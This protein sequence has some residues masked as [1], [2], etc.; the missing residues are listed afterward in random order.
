ME[1]NKYSMAVVSYWCS[2]RSEAQLLKSDKQYKSKNVE[3]GTG[4]V[5]PIHTVRNGHFSLRI[6]WQVRNVGNTA[7]L[8]MLHEIWR[9]WNKYIKRQQQ[10]NDNNIFDC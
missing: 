4:Y 10:S 9:V 6:V 7:I 5:R 3:I 8:F 2:W 1:G